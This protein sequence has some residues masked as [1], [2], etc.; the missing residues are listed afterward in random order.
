MMLRLA[1]GYTQIRLLKKLTAVKRAVVILKHATKKYVEK[2]NP[3]GIESSKPF[4]VSPNSNVVLVIS[5][6]IHVVPSEDPDVTLIT[7]T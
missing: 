1:I 5:H 4:E 2:H 3:Y 7:P 6:A